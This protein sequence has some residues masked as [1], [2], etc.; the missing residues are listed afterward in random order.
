MGVP[1]QRHHHMLAIQTANERP[2]KRATRDRIDVEQA[3]RSDTERIA[4]PSRLSW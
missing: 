1:T 3:S 4:K 2:P